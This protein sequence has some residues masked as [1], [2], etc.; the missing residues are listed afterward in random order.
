MK[1]LVKCGQG[2]RSCQVICI[3]NAGSPDMAGYP[4]KICGFLACRQVAQ[5]VLYFMDYGVGRMDGLYE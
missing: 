2:S 4:A 3:F 5:L 1:R